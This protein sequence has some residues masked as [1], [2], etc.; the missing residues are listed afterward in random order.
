MG[1]TRGGVKEIGGF[2]FVVR[3]RFRV[4]LRV[5]LRIILIGVLLVL[6]VVDVCELGALGAAVVFF[7]GGVH[8]SG[9]K[10]SHHSVVAAGVG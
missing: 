9:R 6:L 1:R 2:G 3:V 7:F 5:C 10:V 8:F 4:G